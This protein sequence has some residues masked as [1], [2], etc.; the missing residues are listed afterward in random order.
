[1]EKQVITKHTCE[2][3][4]SLLASQNGKITING[5]TFSQREPV[6]NSKKVIIKNETN[7]KVSDSN[8]Q[9][10]DMLEFI[11]KEITSIFGVKVYKQ[12]E[13]FTHAQLYQYGGR[14]DCVFTLSF[15]EGSVS[16][17]KYGDNI[18]GCFIY[19]L[20][21]RISMENNPTALNNNP[22]ANFRVLEPSI[23]IEKT[24]ELL[25][26]GILVKDIVEII[27]NC[28]V[29][30]NN[31]FPSKEIRTPNVLKIPF[32]SLGNG[33]DIGW[34]YGLF[35]RMKGQNIG[36]MPEN[37]AMYLAYK[38]VLEP[39]ELTNEERKCMFDREG[40][41]INND[42]SYHY[43]QWKNKAGI[44]K[45]NEKKLL[46]TL[47]RNRLNERV[48]LIV[49]ALKDLGYNSSNFINKYPTQALNM[50]E[51]ALTFNDQNYNVTGKY[52]LYLNFK[53]LLHIYLRHVKE[54]SVCSQF[55]NR[56]KFQLE[57]NDVLTVIGIVMRRLNPEYQKYKEKN[58]NGRF[59]RKGNMA[60]Y[61]CGDYYNVVVNSDG[62]ISTFY[63]GLGNLKE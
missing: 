32:E 48:A 38:L 26:T 22:Y 40:K 10:Q 33:K 2:F 8:I 60:Y 18:T 13:G 51:K 27:V 53:S 9:T 3:N 47:W 17:Q 52:P 16:Y 46:C 41:L 63:R 19:S 42:V 61:Y 7:G 23:C 14:E 36:L 5:E 54:M 56:D 43:L 49:L 21:E 55:E 28:M 37:I 29:K 11:E 4:R 34:M 6:G 58:P 39:H 24:N 35:K 45:E 25:K 62:S 20:K 12:Q 31:T 15:K 50:F 57:E 30:E 59:F 1:M 44:I